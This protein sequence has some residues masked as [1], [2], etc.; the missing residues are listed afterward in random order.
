MESR[1]VAEHYDLIVVGVGSGGIGAALAAAR[2]GLA[3]LLVEQ[4]HVIGG[5][6]VRAGVSMWEPGVG[7]TGIPFDIY[8]RLQAIPQAAAIY[9]YGRHFCWP[10]GEGFPGGEHVIDPQRGYADTLRRY[11]ARS[12]AED[13]AFCREHWHGVV[14]EPFAY[15]CL[16]RE[17]L[18]ETG[19][20]TVLTRT[21]F[22]DVEFA[23]GRV[24]ALTLSTGQRVT[25]AAFVDATGDGVLCQACG[26][27]ML[28]GPEGRARF[29]EPG[30]PEV[31]GDR[32]NGVTLMFRITPAETPE[33]EGLPDDV[34]AHC[35]WADNFAVVSMTHYPNG[36]VNVNMLPTMQGITFRE[37]G[38]ADAYTECRQR[39]LAQWHHVQMQYP[40]FRRYRIAWIAPVLGVRETVR[41]VGEYVLTE[42][43]LRAGLSRQ[44][45]PDIIALADHAMDHHG[46]GGGCG[47]LS[48][49][50]GVPYRCLIPKGF[51]NLLIACRATSFSALAASSCRLS[52]TMMQLGQAAGTAAALAL[53]AGIDLPDVSP[54]ALRTCLRAQHVQ[55]E[56]PL[57]DDLRA[58][59]H[60]V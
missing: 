35:W 44:T 29:G 48:E 9:S 47:E 1:S 24:R 45:H 58:Y 14:F 57:P 53:R 10:G 25:A 21:S 12:L 11:G 20:C 56:H 27:E 41:V 49:L 19:D 18:A 28:R 42:H 50:Y 6:A 26:C 33:I 16:V 8:R 5:N 7:G 22:R 54:D 38:Y 60:V 3:V 13:E 23:D 55:L 52:R 15:A 46:E 17:M 43:D 32:V 4:G 36:D 31:T 39:V 34:P 30:A 2:E 59:L 51:R 37:M 40:E